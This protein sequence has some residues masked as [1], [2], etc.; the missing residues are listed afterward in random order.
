[1]AKAQKNFVCSN[2]G[3]VT[4]KWSGRC[5]GCGEWN[6]ISE[7]KPLSASGP[8]KK[9]LGGLRGKEIPLSALSDK[10]APPKRT[11][12]GLTEFDRVLGGGLVPSSAILVGGDPGIGK[13]TLLLQAAAKFA[14]AGLKV[15]YISGEESAAQVRMRAQRLGLGNAPVRLG[16]ETN[17]R[18][19]LTTLEAEMPDL[20]IID[21]IQTMWADNVESAPGSVSQVRAAA[22]ELVTF[23]KSRGVSVVLV[24]HVTKDGQLAGPRVVEHMV[25]TVLY[26]E[27]ER[28]HHFRLLRAVKNRFGP[29]HEIG[30]FEMTGDGLREVTNPSALFLSE[31]DQ[32]VPG[33]VVFAGI[34]GTR[35]VLVEFQALVAPSPHAQARRTVVGW[36]G[37]RLAMILAVL[38]SR[39]GIPFAGL[40]VYLNVAG[41]MKV[42][43]PAADLAVAAALISAREDQ[44]LPKD[45][46]VFGELSLSGSLRPV[47]QTENRLKEAKKLGFSSAIAPARSKAGEKSGM[48]V[49]QM[50]DLVGFVGEVFGAG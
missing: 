33:S 22:H 36:D 31:R 25:D 20:V 48:D 44:A 24:G 47:G 40:D 23:A 19:I 27:G 30:V 16:A 32:P 7:E 26:F 37:S 14:M 39:C 17:L 45:C 29:A 13:S 28:G 49:R 46:V 50:S 9:T 5:D 15:I 38:E 42:S 34:E 3:A 21:S 2:C 8:A 41:G 11:S 1:M 12:C 10:E 6:S 18:D 35:P 4:T 43:E